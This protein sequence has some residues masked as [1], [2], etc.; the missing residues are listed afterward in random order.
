MNRKNRITGLLAENYFNAAKSGCDM[1]RI[2]AILEDIRTTAGEADPFDKLDERLDIRLGES[3]ANEKEF[4]FLKNL[5]GDLKKLKQEFLEHEIHHVLS[6][7]QEKGRQR[8]LEIFARELSR[9]NL[10]TCRM[11]LDVSIPHREREDF[12]FIETH[13]RY[14]K[15]ERW[16]KSLPLIEYFIAADYLS[17]TVKAD[18][19]I[20]AAQIHLYHFFDLPRALEHCKKVQ[21]LLPDSAKPDRMFGEYYIHNKEFDKARI[22]LQK[23]LDKD[24]NDFENYIVLGSLHK[25]ENRFDSAASWYSEGLKINPGKADLYNQLLLLNECPAHYKKNSSG[26]GYL[27]DSIIRL[28]PD[29][30]FT[31]LNNAGFVHQKNGN[32]TSAEKYY[33]QAAE[34]YPDR[35]QGYIN[36]G[37]SCLERNELK[38]SEHYFRVAT[39]KDPEA[40]D[41]YW[42]LVALYRMKGDWKSVI[43]NLK[44]S[45]KYRP[46]WHQFIYNEFGAAYENMGDTV[47]AQTYYLLA[48]KND[49]EKSLG[50]T[51]L[52][53]IAE[54]DL[55]MKDGLQLM[56]EIRS[57]AGSSFDA[58]FHYRTGII[59]FKN[60]YLDSA[61]EHFEAAVKLDPKNPAKLEY[62]G[63]AYEK[64]GYSDRAEEYYRRAVSESGGD[65]SRYYNRLGFFLSEQ[66]KAQE[67]VAVLQKAIEI[68]PEPVYYE[69]LGFAHEQLGD[70]QKA[71]TSYLRALETADTEKDI[72]ENRLGVFYYNRRDYQNAIT[73]YM[74]A[75]GLASKPVYYENLGLAYEN[76]QQPKKAEESYRAA[77]SAAGQD[78]DRYYNR[79]AFYLSAIGRHEEA[80]DLLRKA[81][82]LQPASRYYENL[83]YAYENLGQAKEAESSYREA[84]ERASTDRD[85]YLNRL[86][87]FFY[88]RQNYEEAANYYR[89]AI[90][91]NPLPIYYENLANA[92]NDAGNRKLFEE[93]LL[94]AA[95]KEPQEGKYYFQ[96]GWNLLHKYNDIQQSK[97]WLYKAIEV[98]KITPEIEPEELL[99]IQFLGAAYQQ[100]GNLDRAEEIFR[101]AYELDSGNETLCSFLGKVYLEKNEPEKA[102]YYYERALEIAPHN[103]V[104]IKNATDVWDRLG[105]TEKIIGL[106]KGGASKH[107]ELNDTLARIYYRQEDYPSALK[108]FARA[109]EA[110]PGN[111]IYRENMA[112]TLKQLQKYDEARSEFSRARELAPEE[113]QDIYLNYIGNCWF[114]EGDFHTAAENYRKALALNPGNPVYQKNLMDAL[115][116]GKKYEEA[117]D[118]IE[119]RLEENPSDKDALNTL[120]LVYFEMG[121]TDEAMACFNSY[122]NFYPSDPLGYDNLGF[123]YEKAGQT[124]EAIETYSKGLPYDNSF[125]EKIGK[126][127]FDRED[128]ANA[129]LYIRRALEKDPANSVYLSCLGIVLDRQD[130]LQESE[131]AFEKALELEPRPAWFEVLSGVKE[132]LGKMGEAV[133]CLQKAIRNEA[134]YKDKYH[135]LLAGLYERLGN[136]GKA[137]EHY[138]EATGIYQAAHY[139]D[140]WG[141]LLLG[142]GENE[143]AAQVYLQAL[144]AFPGDTVFTEN[145]RN[146][147]SGISDEGVRKAF[148]DKVQEPGVEGARTVSR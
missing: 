113:E 26:I 57:I 137:S 116:S 8:W 114:A 9:L 85:I 60:N 100:E 51:A 95:E 123:C 68:K 74:N 10:E 34:L 71:E 72:Y 25:A 102:V 138:R 133:E 37:Y 30:K 67:A 35:I 101:E 18:L 110:F 50:I 128:Y 129:T 145:F 82:R 92:Y 24:K 23:A 125:N 45:E 87:I 126:I 127:Y 19:N 142:Q 49:P 28:N 130:Q 135:Y 40:F 73:R 83:G 146:A 99:S 80:V 98:F 121:K 79:L 48:L 139:F 117:R 106:C 97:I 78:K 11:L 55:E 105:E 89:Q 13:T 69:N 32:Y 93:S 47:R 65:N 44:I 70:Y 62:L 52:C 1:F 88:N 132:K 61:V 17:N 53:D 15:E 84:V 43:E 104:N 33:Q 22:H 16:D 54:L 119:K 148:L 76:S 94:K 112:T 81:I 131:Q 124:E 90:D 41:G 122:V 2:T 36:M 108:Y 96:L 46:Q 14:V 6:E 136:A 42:G 63:L 147:C 12:R 5:E 141:N 58:V 66:G 77:V 143:Q 27:L 64:T 118:L 111:Y 103:M 39:T 4:S 29:F 140:G 7:N 86:G 59:Y 144:K 20:I 21:W 3:L 31:A 109:V 120:G 134:E 107:P 91:I 75:V 115:R 56:K 38:L